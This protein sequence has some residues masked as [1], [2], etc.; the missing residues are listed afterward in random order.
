MALVLLVILFSIPLLIE[1]SWKFF[2]LA[3]LLALTYLILQPF[4]GVL[5]YKRQGV[6]YLPLNPFKIDISWM[7]NLEKVYVKFPRYVTSVRGPY[8]FLYLSSPELVK[9]LLQVRQRERER[10]TV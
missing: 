6:P 7:I 9:E 4:L 5:Y 2:C 1:L 3:I 8:I 10:V